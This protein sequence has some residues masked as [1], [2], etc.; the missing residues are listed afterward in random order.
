MKPLHPRFRPLQ[1]LALHL[2]LIATLALHV[3]AAGAQPMPFT[4]T[5]RVAPLSDVIDGRQS[6]L[7]TS[8]DGY[9]L[10]GRAGFSLHAPFEFNFVTGL[11]EGTFAIVKGGD[12][13]VGDLD[14]RLLSNM[15]LS[16]ELSYT[17]LGGNGVFAGATGSG[18]TTVT[19]TGAPGADGFPY[20]EVGQLT[21]AAVPE[22]TSWALMLAGG[23]LLAARRRHRTSVLQ[24]GQ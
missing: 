16:F 3:G 7:A 15:P 6:L 21:V 23:T 5:G 17:V 4:G 9:S 14:T 10:A 13:L 18:L 12:R 19:I 24:Q 11:G 2:A 22:P 20:F 8:V 1:S